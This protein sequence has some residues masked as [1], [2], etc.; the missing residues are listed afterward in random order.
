MADAR[1]S[2]NETGEKLTDL[3]RKLKVHYEAQHGTDSQQSRQELTDAAHRVGG[4]LQDV[5]EALGAAAKDKAVQADVKQ[6]GQSLIE[7]LGAT[8]GQASEELRRAF[9]ERKGEAGPVPEPAP[10]APHEEVVTTD[11]PATGGPATGTPAAGEPGG[12]EPPA[13]GAPKVEPWGTP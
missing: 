2:W 1:G 11:A 5:F 7:A 12:E 13:P 4:A 3:G 8:L 10:A 9:S 6:V